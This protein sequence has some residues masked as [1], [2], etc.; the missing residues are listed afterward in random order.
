MDLGPRVNA[1][2]QNCVIAITMPVQVT[3]PTTPGI[4]ARDLHDLLHSFWY[5]REEVFQIKSRS[6][7]C[8]SFQS[9]PHVSTILK[10]LPLYPLCLVLREPPF[11]QDSNP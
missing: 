9:I 8:L 2:L 11:F 5:G 4:A 3:I 1:C 7:P 6:A 10:S